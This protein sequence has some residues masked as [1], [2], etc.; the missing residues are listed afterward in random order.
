QQSARGTAR[1]DPARYPGG[2]ARPD[3]AL[4]LVG[5]CLALIAALT[6]PHAVVVLWMD[7]VQGV[8]RAPARTRFKVTSP[9]PRNLFWRPLRAQARS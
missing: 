2:W 6:C 3:N 9:I 4:D 1:R 7:A 5:L 8:W